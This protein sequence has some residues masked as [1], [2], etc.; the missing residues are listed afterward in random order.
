[1]TLRR[2][3]LGGTFDP[4]HNGHLILAQEVLWRLGVDGVWFIP[5]GLPW[6]KREILL[7]DKEHRRKM[8]EIAIAGNPA[9]HLS[10]VELDRPGDTFTIDTLDELRAG[11]MADGE[12]LLVIGAD[13]LRT[14]HLWKEPKRMLDMA[15]LVVA[16]RAGSL[17]LD[18]RELEAIGVSATH[19]ITTVEM[20]LV[21]ISGT[22]LRR[23]VRDGEPV[24]YLAPDGV[25]DYIEESGLYQR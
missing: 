21:D 24:R 4:I 11:E 5:A 3:L 10:T 15:Q 23:R 2:A 20:P 18:L 6:M 19:R 8:V 17:E 7:S 13:T 1:M 16:K 22:E 25:A 9:F 12:L 14:V